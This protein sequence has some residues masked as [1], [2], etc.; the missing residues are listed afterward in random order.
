MTAV[1]TAPPTPA[2]WLNY[3]D[4]DVE[5]VG[6]VMGPTLHGELLTVVEVLRHGLDVGAE[7]AH[8]CVGF[9]YGIRCGVCWAVIRLEG[10]T[11]DPTVLGV[12][13]LLGEGLGRR[14][15]CGDHR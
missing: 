11:N 1:A 15:L 5:T 2:K 6:R 8:A 14:A 13:L 12:P 4:A 3:P 9:V 7:D 10:A